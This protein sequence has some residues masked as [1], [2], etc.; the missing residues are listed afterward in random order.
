MNSGLYNNENIDHVGNFTKVFLNGTQSILQTLFNVT[1][2]GYY[3][4]QW[5]N[6]NPHPLGVAYSMATVHPG[7]MVPIY[8]QT[9]FL[10]LAAATTGIGAFIWWRKRRRSGPG[11]A[12]QLHL[13]PT[14]SPRDPRA[15]CSWAY[16]EHL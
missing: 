14:P 7:A 11:R 4:P 1:L 16:N 2:D 15:R 8:L 13:P 12:G 3:K 5:L 6:P 10:A 9:P